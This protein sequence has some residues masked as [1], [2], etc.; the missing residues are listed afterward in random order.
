MLAKS[1]VVSQSAGLFPRAARLHRLGDG[2][3]GFGN[4]DQADGS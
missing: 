1:M 4:Y 2:S 3:Y